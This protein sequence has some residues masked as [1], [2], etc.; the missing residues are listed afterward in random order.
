MKRLIG[1]LAA[2]TLAAAPQ[3]GADIHDLAQLQALIESRHV[4]SVEDLLAAL[5]AD[6]RS[7][8]TLVFDSRS[9]QD[10]SFENPRAIL[11]SADAHFVLSFNGDPAQRGYGAVETMT[12]DAPNNRFEFREVA[13]AGGAG[14]GGAVSYSAPGSARCAACHGQRARPVWDTVP[15]WP[16]VY[17]ERYHAGLSDREA[18]GMRAFLAR[19]PEHPRYRYLLGATRFGERDTYVPSSRTLY[20]GGVA[21]PPNAEFGS[22]LWAMNVRSIIAE[23]ALRPAFESHRYLLLAAAG[24]GCGAPADFYPPDR[25]ADVRRRRA[26]FIAATAAADAR[27]ALAK[28]DRATRTGPAYHGGTGSGALTDFRFV[29]ENDLGLSTA[30]WTL[31]LEKGSYDFA[32]PAG[33]N[34][35]GLSLFEW[36]ATTDPQLRS[37]SA[38][39][40]LSSDD[41]YCT[42]IRNESRQLLAAWQPTAIA[43]PAVAAIDA[44]RPDAAARPVLVERCVACHTT[45]VAPP[46]PF[47]Q[48]HELAHALLAGHYPRGRLLDEILY[49]LTPAAGSARMPRGLA[50]SDAEQRELESYFLALSGRGETGPPGL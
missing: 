28:H 50:I 13:F 40:G 43:V 45:E 27:Q 8:Y 16:G 20:N 29:V 14:Q 10:A 2:L 39:R 34:E 9:L 41:A 25:R 1:P 23:L 26:A 37:L 30:E 18:Q 22:L 31:A 3:A 36:L 38:L 35:I 42:H 11:Y 21:E 24:A 15:E 6:L 17:G 47:D 12:F 32:T 4:H 7:R 48:E 33:L 44:G 5:P 49:R 46:L 19:Q